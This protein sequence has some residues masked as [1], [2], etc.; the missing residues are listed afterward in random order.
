MAAQE[1]TMT[2][3]PFPHGE[4]EK[5]GD[6]LWSV[7][8][9]MPRS[10]LPRRM[11]VARVGDGRLIIHSAIALEQPHMEQLEQW[12]TPA[13]LVVPNRFH[14]FDAAAYKDRY[15]DLRVLCPDEARSQV[16]QLV[17]VDGSTDELDEE[18]ELQLLA[19]PGA[20][21][22]EFVLVVRHAD[23]TASAV[24][25]DAIFNLPHQPGLGGLIMK[26]I[27]SSGGPRVTRL[28]KMMMVSNAAAF[29]GGLREL[30]AVDGLCRVL[31]SHGDV[32]EGDAPGVLGQIA[33]RL[34]A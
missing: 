19:L 5:Y 21:G 34:R 14:R 9:S 22:G 32:I 28:A 29:A 6:N 10:P 8:G 11:C 24:V 4:I 2:W 7:V 25:T 20:K 31:P 3:Q 17:A 27:G 23:G 15:P 33:D 1:D 18:S 26:W 12:G 30:A 16:Q 13:V